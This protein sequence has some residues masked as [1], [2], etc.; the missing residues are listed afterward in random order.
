MMAIRWRILLLL[1]L[2]RSV[3]AFQFA[4]IGAIAPLIGNEFQVDAVA[5]GTL[6]G[7]QAGC[8]DRA[9]SDGGR[10]RPDGFKRHVGGAD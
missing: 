6:I 1:F 8:F 5:I 4:T 3:M 2:I 7:R 10:Q 9:C